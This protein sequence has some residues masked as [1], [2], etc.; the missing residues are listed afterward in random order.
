MFLNRNQFKKRIKQLVF[1]SLVLFP[2]CGYMRKTDKPNLDLSIHPYLDYYPDKDVPNEELPIILRE[3][4]KAVSVLPPVLQIVNRE[5]K[6]LTI[7]KIRV[8][9]LETDFLCHPTYN[10]ANPYKKIKVLPMKMD[11]G[12]ILKSIAYRIQRQYLQ[13]RNHY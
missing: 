5:H 2:A 11:Y 7:E 12:D 1:L 13:N 3:R 8:D 9:G 6:E 10:L 4:K